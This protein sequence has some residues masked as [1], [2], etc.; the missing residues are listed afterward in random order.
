M[1]Y[2]SFRVAYNIAVSP[3]REEISYLFTTTCSYKYVKFVPVHTETVY[4][5]ISNSTKYPGCTGTVVFIFSVS[6]TF[7]IQEIQLYIAATIP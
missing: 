6:M 3:V 4:L 7:G 1:H 5:K 2:S